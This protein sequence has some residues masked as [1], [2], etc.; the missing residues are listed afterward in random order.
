MNI[1]K[2]HVFVQWIF[3]QHNAINHMYNEDGAVPVPY[4]FHLEMV[5]RILDRKELN[6][7]NVFNFLLQEYGIKKTELQK[8]AYAHDSIED[9]PTRVSYN[10]LMNAPGIT[11]NNDNRKTI[12]EL[13]FAVSND[14]GRNRKERNS[15]AYYER[16]RQQPGAT[17]IK[18]A[19]R[20][21]NVEFGILTGNHGKVKTY[22]E[23]YNKL[24]EEIY[25]PIYDDMFTYLANRLGI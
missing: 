23:E 20:I 9:V 8:A 13:V 3:E 15:A 7:E 16:I 25:Y 21:A 6:L 1:D 24:K 22:Y 17:L 11:D 18:M 4:T 19:D 10:N 14:R 2:S 12:C 5:A